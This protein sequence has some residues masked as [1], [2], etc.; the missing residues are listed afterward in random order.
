MFYLRLLN[1]Q[2][3]ENQIFWKGFGLFASKKNIIKRHKKYNTYY[4]F[5]VNNYHN[6]YAQIFS[7]AGIF[8]LLMLL[9]M[10]FHMI[11]VALLSK[12]HFWLFISFSFALIFMTESLLWRQ[13]GLFLFI[14]LYCLLINTKHL[15]VFKNKMNK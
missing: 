4:T 1:E 14:I 10:L 7:E 12:N 11:K 3:N 2:I 6:Q 9:L 8:G 15:D 5:H 13:R